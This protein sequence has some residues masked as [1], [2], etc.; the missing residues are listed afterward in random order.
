MM[1]IFTVMYAN[2]TVVQIQN[3]PVHYPIM[4][5]FVTNVYMCAYFCYEMVRDMIFFSLI[6]QIV[7]P[8]CCL[9]CCCHLNP[10]RKMEFE[11]ANLNKS[12]HSY[13]SQLDNIPVAAVL[14]IERRGIEKIVLACWVSWWDS[15]LKCT[16]SHLSTVTSMLES[17]KNDRGNFIDECKLF[18]YSPDKAHILTLQNPNTKA[19][20]SVAFLV[21]LIGLITF[22]FRWHS[23]RLSYRKNTANV[24]SII[25]RFGI[26]TFIHN[27]FVFIVFWICVKYFLLR[28]KCI[29]RELIWLGH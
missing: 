28:S 8:V 14:L 6:M 26:K 9:L 4:H 22:I 15:G 12:T 23:A 21:R 2:K 11:Q 19:P 16:E 24:L 7:R 18:L 20:F 17:P 3:A 1:Y 29:Y 10:N 13:L 25:K 27:W 5:H